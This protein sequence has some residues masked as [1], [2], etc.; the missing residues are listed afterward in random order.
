MDRWIDRTKS[1]EAGTHSR[2]QILDGVVQ[3]IHGPMGQIRANELHKEL[4]QPSSSEVMVIR[5]SSKR[6]M[7]SRHTW[8]ITFTEQDMEGVS[9][10]IMTLWS[11][12]SPS[13]GR[14]F[15]AYWSINGARRRFCTT[16]HSRPLVSPRNN[17]SRWTPP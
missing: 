6:K 2:A 12:S 10:P 3:C 1:L 4:Y 11:F 13:S 15:A 8:E 7:D 17:W 5:S 16:R 9:F 14:W